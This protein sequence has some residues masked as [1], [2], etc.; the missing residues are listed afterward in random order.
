MGG[1]I[2]HWFLKVFKLS[3]LYLILL[4]V[5]LYPLNSLYFRFEVRDKPGVLSEITKLFSN[6]NIS[7]ERV[8]QIPDFKKKSASIVIITHKTLE[9]NYKNLLVNLAKNKFVLSKPT[10]IRVEKI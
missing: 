4:I 2:L 1:Q 6:N 3:I 10:F 5:L 7:I 8:I 9:N